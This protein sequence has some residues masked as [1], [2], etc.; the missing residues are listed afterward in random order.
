M[1]RFGEHGVRIEPVDSDRVK[2]Y[3]VRVLP[4]GEEFSY[5]EPY[6]TVDV[7]YP[8]TN[9]MIDVPL[10]ELEEGPTESGRYIAYVTSAGDKDQE[11]DPVTD[12]K[13]WV[14][15]LDPLPAPASVEVY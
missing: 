8:V 12:D 13:V 10:E 15:D 5:D 7:D 2:S 3:R 4:E 11:S 6:S 1:A 14:L 9:G